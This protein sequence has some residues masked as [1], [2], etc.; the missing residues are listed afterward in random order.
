MQYFN[1][2]YYQCNTWTPNNIIAI[3][4]LKFYQCNIWTPNIT[5]AIFE[6]K[7]LCQQNVPETRSRSI[8]LLT[9]VRQT[10]TS[11]GP[12]SPLQNRMRAIL[13]FCLLFQR[14]EPPQKQTR[15]VLILI[16]LNREILE[17]TRNFRIFEKWLN[18]REILESSRNYRIFEKL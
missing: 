18:L 9:Q 12:Q 3:F 5:N 1:S 7:T 8:A 17:P 15:R 16:L 2:K 13:A 14:I 4:E 6:L 10:K 11:W